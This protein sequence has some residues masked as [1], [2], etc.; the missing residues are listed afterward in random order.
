MGPYFILKL[1]YDIH[2]GF[3]FRILTLTTVQMINGMECQIQ[4]ATKGHL[5]PR[6]YRTVSLL[7]GE[8]QFLQ[9]QI[10]YEQPDQIGF[11][12]YPLWSQTFIDKIIKE[13][14]VE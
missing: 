6:Q 8:N 12:H 10:I 9:E 11:P 1:A 3:H 14:F 13:I 5:D 4:T 7:L 2:R